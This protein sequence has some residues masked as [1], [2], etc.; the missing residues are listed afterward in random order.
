M[1]YFTCFK[2]W[3]KN[4]V[5]V[6]TLLGFLAVTVMVLGCNQAIKNLDPDL[7]GNIDN[8]CALLAVSFSAGNVAFSI[9]SLK[10]NVGKNHCPVLQYST[11][12]R[13][14]KSSIYSHCLSNTDY[15]LFNSFT[16]KQVHLV[17]YLQDLSPPLLL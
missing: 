6:N 5:I 16:W 9:R 13:T 3:L 7:S 11:I 1:N 17:Y 10:N 8:D 12:V 2:R 15:A 14:L 4:H